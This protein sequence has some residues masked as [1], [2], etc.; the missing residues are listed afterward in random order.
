M[1]DIEKMLREFM[2]SDLLAFIPY[3]FLFILFLTRLLT[4]EKNLAFT[5]YRIV[6]IGPAKVGKTTTLIAALDQIRRGKIREGLARLRSESTISRVSNLAAILNAGKFPPATKEDETN[7]YRFDYAYR[8][9]VILRWMLKFVGVPTLF[10]VEVADFAGEQSERYFAENPVLTAE[11]MPDDFGPNASHNFLKW[12]SESDLCMMF[13]DC[14]EYRESG[15]EYIARI[16]E[17]YITFWTFYLDIHADSILASKAPPVVVVYTK[18]DAVR[19]V[20]SSG[21]ISLGEATSFFDEKFSEL[22]SFLKQN[23][24]RVRTIQTSAISR[25]DKGERLGVT[26][27]VN[28]IL[29][30]R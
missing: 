29:P 21:N 13:I 3:V 27:L 30:G 7:V 22:L 6:L 11:E 26:E 8:H 12:I 9:S 18:G 24:S 14:E 5:S 15:Q 16:T 25:N 23:S 2:I 17:K 20:N 4:S 1:I 10:R 28:Y 19:L